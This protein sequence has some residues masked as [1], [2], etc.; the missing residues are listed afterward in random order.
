MQDRCGRLLISGCR[1]CKSG[2]STL[3][4]P[5][6]HQLASKNI[7]IYPFQRLGR[8]EHEVT[9]LRQAA[10]SISVDICHHESHGDKQLD[11][12]RILSRYNVVP[13]REEHNRVAVGRHLAEPHRRE[14]GHL[15]VKV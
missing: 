2:L 10:T 1:D 9:V 4:V 15:E 3:T 12:H 8:T 6:H 13:V 5:G 14:Q 11:I 7:S